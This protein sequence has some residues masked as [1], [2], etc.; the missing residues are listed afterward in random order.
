MQRH[1]RHKLSWS[2]KTERAGERKCEGAMSRR[3]PSF[4]DLLQRNHR[5]RHV[6]QTICE[7]FERGRQRETEKRE[8]K[9]GSTRD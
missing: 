6:G 8:I 1:I 3:R 7:A 4:G 2:A 5:E 9:N